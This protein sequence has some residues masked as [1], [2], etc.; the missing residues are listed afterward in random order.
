MLRTFINMKLQEHLVAQRS[1]RKHSA[2]RMLNNLDRLSF[3]H[4]T[5]GGILC[6]AD[7]SGVLEI[8]LLIELLA[9]NLDLGCIDDDYI[10]AAVKKGV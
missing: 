3:K 7:P 8:N 9:G 6:I 5:K 4:L 2:N 10:V 1:V